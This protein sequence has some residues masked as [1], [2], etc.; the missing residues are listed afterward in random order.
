M[1]FLALSGISSCRVMSATA[2]VPPAFSARNA[3]LNT[4]CLSGERLITQFDI[5]KSTAPE[6]MGRCSISPSLNSVF[7]YVV[8]Y[9]AFVALALHTISGVASTPIAFPLGPTSC[10][11]LKMSIP[12]PLP[13]SS[14]ASPCLGLIRARGDPHPAFTEEASTGMSWATATGVESQQS[15]LP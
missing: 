8:P 13:R 11:A 4:A 1:S 7:E 14:T 15:A 6:P 5:T 2:K 12:P 9:F 3:S 10:D